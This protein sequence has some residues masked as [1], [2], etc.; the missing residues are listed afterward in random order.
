MMH[1]K[2]RGQSLTDQEVQNAMEL[3]ATQYEAIV[4]D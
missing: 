2:Y 1:S 4:P 3:A